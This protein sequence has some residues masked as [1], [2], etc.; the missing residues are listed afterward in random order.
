MN[1]AA[2]RV[3]KLG[4]SLLS[5]DRLGEVLHAWLESQSPATNLLVIGGGSLVDAVQIE[6]E[7][8]GLSDDLAHERALRAMGQTARQAAEFL[9]DP[10]RIASPED[11]WQAEGRLLLLLDP[12]RFEEEWNRED[13][14]KPLPRSWDVTSDSIAARV[15][16]VL[17][18]NELVLLKSTLPTG[19]TTW[20]EAADSG[21]V[22]RC[23]PQVAAQ[24]RVI[25]CVNLRAPG[26]LEWSTD[27][28]TE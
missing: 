25:R 7:A 6:A 22:D 8:D 18:A 4:G 16:L 14:G 13:Q 24:L 12:V 3:I 1:A 2:L 23:F 11:A 26:A 17:K 5:M 15:A 19:A 9:E 20:Q 21:Y 28:L 27:G 10:W